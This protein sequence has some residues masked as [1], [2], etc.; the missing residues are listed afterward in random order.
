M[1]LNTSSV[2]QSDCSSHHVIK[3]TFIY[4]VQTLPPPRQKRE[5]VFLPQNKNNSAV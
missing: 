1:S 3:F 5:G 4:G 2:T